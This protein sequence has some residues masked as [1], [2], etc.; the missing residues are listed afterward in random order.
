MSTFKHTSS[1]E[2]YGGNSQISIAAIDSPESNIRSFDPKLRLKL[3]CLRS[4]VLDKSTD[5]DFHPLAA[6]TGELF[7]IEYLYSE[8]GSNLTLGVNIDI[9]IEE[10]LND[11]DDFFTFFPEEEDCLDSELDVD[12][13]NDDCLDSELDVAVLSF[14]IDEEDNSEEDQFLDFNS[15]EG[16]DK[17]V[18]LMKL[19]VDI[20]SLSISTLDAEK[21]VQSYNNLSPY[22]KKPIS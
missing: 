7:G 6:Y 3:K 15:I 21:I 2:L 16:W 20:K 11:D 12:V 9:E 5:I 18:E 14:M 17:V 4:A 19:L 8:M 13:L 10:G 1:K 22:D